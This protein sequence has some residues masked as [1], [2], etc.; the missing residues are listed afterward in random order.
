LTT[1]SGFGLAA[2]VFV[3]LLIG[4]SFTVNSVSSTALKPIRMSGGA[5]K[6][7]SGYVLMVVGG[8]FLTLAFLSTPIIGG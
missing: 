2:F 4:A 1:V 8:W 6:T 7:F 3:S 5:V